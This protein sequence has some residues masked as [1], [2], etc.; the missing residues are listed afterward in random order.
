MK[1]LRRLFR[2]RWARKPQAAP[3]ARLRLEP[4]EARRLMS[5][6]PTLHGGPELPSVGITGVFLGTD[7]QAAGGVWGMLGMLNSTTGIVQS[8]FMD[9]LGGAGYGVGRGGV[10]SALL[11][12]AFLPAGAPLTQQQ[13]EADLA[14]GLLFSSTLPLQLAANHMLV[15]YVQPGVQVSASFGGVGYSS[16]PGAAHP[17]LGYHSTLNFWGWQ[18]PYAV[19]AWPGGSNIGGGYDAFTAALSHEIAETV[20][21]PFGNGWYTQVGNTLTEIGD[22]LNGVRARMSNGIVVQ[23]LLDPHGNTITPPGSTLL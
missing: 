17:M 22:T 8:P 10:D 5:V 1:W 20:T 4:L 2:R 3:R 16:A 9:M 21:N 19:V 13:I 6:A 23:A 18:V 11:V 7:W 15:V 12:P 14:W